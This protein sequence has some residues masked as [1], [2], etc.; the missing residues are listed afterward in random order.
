MVAAR[1]RNGGAKKWVLKADF[2]M[3]DL[4]SLLEV[5]AFAG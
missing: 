4:R 5:Q 1:F 2:P 3:R